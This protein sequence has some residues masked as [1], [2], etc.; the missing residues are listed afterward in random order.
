[1]SQKQEVELLK[2]ILLDIGGKEARVE[3]DEPDCYQLL[4]RGTLFN[5]PQ[6]I[7]YNGEMCQC[8][9]NSVF[10]WEKNKREERLVTG[11]ALSNIGV[12]HQH[13]WILYEDNIIETTLPREK[14][15]GYILNEMESENFLLNYKLDELTRKLKTT[16]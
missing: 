7:L 10:L 12:W 8:H 3:D 4:T 1:M 5:K 15:Y 13:S 2:Q 16:S 9:K 6:D 14:Y 11:Y